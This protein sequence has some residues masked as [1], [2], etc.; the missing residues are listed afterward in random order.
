[1]SISFCITLYNAVT[2]GLQVLCSCP[3]LYACTSLSVF[4]IDLLI[5]MMLQPLW[6]VFHNCSVSGVVFPSLT[7]HVCCRKLLGMQ[8]MMRGV[9]PRPYPLPLPAKMRRQAAAPAALTTPIRM[10]LLR[11]MYSRVHVGRNRGVRAGVHLEAAA[12]AGVRVSAGERAGSCRSGAMMA[13]SSCTATQGESSSN[14]M[15]M[16]LML[17][18]GLH[19]ICTF[20]RKLW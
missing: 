1:M 2:L 19:A 14:P 3:C 5:C 11:R 6:P 10:S 18:L 8:P 7:E 17:M 12:E 16:H 13:S 15:L 20:C 9:R 4:L